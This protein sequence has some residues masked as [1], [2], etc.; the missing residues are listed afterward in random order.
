MRALKLAVVVLAI[1]AAI[2]PVSPRIVEDHY[3]RGL[4]PAIQTTLT[5]LSNAVPIALFDSRLP[6]RAR[7]IPPN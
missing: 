1:V 6:R 5:P 3:S 4:Y 2:V 7:D